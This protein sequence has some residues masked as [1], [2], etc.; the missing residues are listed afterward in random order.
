M[1]QDFW[2]RET[3]SANDTCQ[4]HNNDILLLAALIYLLI[5]DGGDRYLIMALIYVIL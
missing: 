3:Y 2:G 5:K 1:H 4:G